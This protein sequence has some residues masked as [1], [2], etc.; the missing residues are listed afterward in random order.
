MKNF[1]YQLFC[2]LSLQGKKQIIFYLVMNMYLQQN[3]LEKIFQGLNFMKLVLYLLMG[4]I[5]LEFLLPLSIM[6]KN[7]CGWE[8]KGYYKIY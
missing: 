3:N 6:L 7:L 5:D 8:I 4:G 2:H 1:H